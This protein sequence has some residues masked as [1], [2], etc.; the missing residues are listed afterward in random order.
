MDEKET[1]EAQ[2]EAIRDVTRHRSRRASADDA[3]QMYLA[4]LAYAE[5]RESTP[6]EQTER[7]PAGRSA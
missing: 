5:S 6:D 3:M 4:G 2:Q 7:R 1:F